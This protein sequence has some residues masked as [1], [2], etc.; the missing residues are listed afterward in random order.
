[1]KRWI[2]I[3]LIVIGIVNISLTFIKENS[4][5]WSLGLGV[6]PLVLGIIGYF[7]PPKS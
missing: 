2:I 5:I 4:W 3:A 7:N 6:L 1:M